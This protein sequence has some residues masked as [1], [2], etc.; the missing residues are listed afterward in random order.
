MQQVNVFACA[1]DVRSGCVRS[2]LV[3]IH[4]IYATALK[5]P[6][7]AGGRGGESTALMQCENVI[8]IDLPFQS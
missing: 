3:R 6:R 8:P 7:E 2:G 1:G 4:S 5:P